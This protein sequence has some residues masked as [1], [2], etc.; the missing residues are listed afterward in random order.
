MIRLMP[1]PTKRW[2]RSLTIWA[3]TGLLVLSVVLAD[4][5]V[6]AALPPE[7]GRYVAMV[8]ALVN[9]ALRFRTNAP[10]GR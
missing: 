3:N 2:Y 7:W 10:I 9:L 4:S 6:T 8:T 5:T 1:R